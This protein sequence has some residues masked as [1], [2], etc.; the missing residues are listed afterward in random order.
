MAE[1]AFLPA[2]LQP[3]L[4]LKLCPIAPGTLTALAMAL[5]DPERRTG[6]QW[7]KGEIQPER[8]LFSL[9][10]IIKGAGTKSNVISSLCHGKGWTREATEPNPT[11]PSSQ[12]IPIVTPHSLKG[13]EGQLGQGR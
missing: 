8:G 6:R 12:R 5:R 3:G 11:L 9:T 1:M 4:D 2:G 7:I 10:P 13:G